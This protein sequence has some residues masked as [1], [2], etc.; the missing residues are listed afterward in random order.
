MNGIFERLQAFVKDL[1]ARFSSLSMPSKFLAGLAILALT[2]FVAVGGTKWRGWVKALTCFFLLC[3]MLFLVLGALM[4][5]LV[6]ILIWFIWKKTKW[7]TWL[8]VVVTVAILAILAALALAFVGKSASSNVPAPSSP[9]T[10]QAT[11]EATPV[12]SNAPALPSPSETPDETP[13]VNE[14]VPSATQPPT[15]EENDHTSSVTT[16]TEDS[17]NTPS[18]APVEDGENMP[19]ETPA[20]DGEDTP[21]ET[22]AEDDF[23]WLT[24]L[25]NLYPGVELYMMVD[26]EPI[27]Y[28]VVTALDTEGTQVQIYLAAGDNA[29]W[30]ERRTPLFSD[31]LKVRSDDTHL[32]QY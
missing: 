27:L 23:K 18:E 6:F 7:K 3:I 28:G 20:E 11:P 9:P 17:E 32:P 22:P 5:A 16:P 4:V 19:S 29:Q 24:A 1:Q 8:K 14:A 31:V 25:G 13:P 30:F 10:I 15:E 2:P 12:P 21:S 26:G